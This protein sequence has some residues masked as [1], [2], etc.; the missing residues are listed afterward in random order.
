MNMRTLF[1]MSIL[2]LMIFGILPVSAA[3]N[4]VVESKE[5]TTVGENATFDFYLDTVPDGLVG[6]IYLIHIDDDSVARITDVKFPPWVLLKANSPNLN[7]DVWIKLLAQP[8][9]PKGSSNVYVGSV[10]V[11]SQKKGSTPITVQLSQ[12]TDLHNLKYWFED[13]NGNVINVTVIPGKISVQGSGSSVSSTVVPTSGSTTVSPSVV[14]TLPPTSSGIPP[15][16]SPLI[17]PEISRTSSVLSTV[18]ALPSVPAKSPVSLPVIIIGG[19][20]GVLLY[21]RSTRKN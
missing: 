10:I 6:A 9:I 3:S 7:N 20:L 1:V 16:V 15:S 12:P 17:S 19:I 5:F 21:I 4:L 8:A 2:M 13:I 14:K 18:T 11:T